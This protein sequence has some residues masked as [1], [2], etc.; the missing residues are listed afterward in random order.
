MCA[1]SKR[2][3]AS[4]RMRLV[5]NPRTRQV[6]GK[7][8]DE[9]CKLVVEERHARLDRGAHG[10]AIAAL[11]QVIRQPAR[12]IEEQNGAQAANHPAPPTAERSAVRPAGGGAVASA[13]GRSHHRS[14]RQTSAPCA[15]RRDSMPRVG[16][17]RLGAAEA[18]RQ[19][20][21]LP[22]RSGRGATSAAAADTALRTARRRVW[23]SRRAPHR[24][25]RRSGP[26]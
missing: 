15:A 2:R 21:R 11:E 14:V 24:T 10:H 22:A 23:D 16:D 12:L 1:G 17:G 9:R 3:I 13:D 20:L 7:R 4:R 26:S 8:R 6:S 18:I 5:V 19:R 25:L